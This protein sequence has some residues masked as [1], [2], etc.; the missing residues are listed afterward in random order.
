MV[1]STRSAPSDALSQ[2]T[3]FSQYIA[4][5]SV[6]RSAWSSRLRPCASC[7]PARTSRA[8]HSARPA[9]RSSSFLDI[10]VP[11]WRRLASWRLRRVGALV[12]SNK[13]ALGSTTGCC[14]LRWHR[15]TNSVRVCSPASRR[16]ATLRPRFAGLTA[17]TPAPRTLV[18][19]GSCR[20][21]LSLH[22]LHVVVDLPCR[23]PRFRMS[24]DTASRP[25]SGRHRWRRP[26]TR[27][28]ARHPHRSLGSRPRGTVASVSGFTV[29]KA[30]TIATRVPLPSCSVSPMRACVRRSGR[31]LA[32][33]SVLTPR[34]VARR[35]RQMRAETMA[36]RASQ[37]SRSRPGPPGSRPQMEE[38]GRLRAPR[39]PV[40]LPNGHPVPDGPTWRREVSCRGSTAGDVGS[41][42]SSSWSRRRKSRF[43]RLSDAQ[44]LQVLD[45]RP[46]L[47]GVPRRPVVAL[48]Q[49]R[50]PGA[51]SHGDQLD[52]EMLRAVVVA[53]GQEPLRQGNRWKL[54]H[55]RIG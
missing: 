33:V 2:P 38:R 46:H 41:R 26:N 3:S 14:G 32:A 6:S 37:S 43:G 12:K 8:K 7:C 9:A 28:T 29:V 20:R 31:S 54:V 45:R 51:P 49:P 36:D 50:S 30:L 52:R 34:T 17:L 53:Q 48:R 15:Q 24:V 16:V 35:G 4:S 22:P 39:A 44:P 55:A 42:S 25:A 10:P 18:Q 1:S 11:V 21:C 19:A 13:S 40:R 5:R 23:I 27:G 47:A